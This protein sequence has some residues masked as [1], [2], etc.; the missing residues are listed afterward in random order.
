MHA[1]NSDDCVQV[2]NKS[3]LPS[4]ASLLEGGGGLILVV[5]GARWGTDVLW[6]STTHRPSNV[7]S[8]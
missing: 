6:S 7:R 8:V 5:V 1:W 3:S 4:P 2:N